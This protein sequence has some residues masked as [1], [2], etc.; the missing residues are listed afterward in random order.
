[1]V[2]L[3]VLAYLLFAFILPE[4]VEINE[5]PPFDLKVFG[6]DVAYAQEFLGSLS[7]IERKSYMRFLW[8]FDFVYPLIY[9]NLLII[10]LSFLS[11]PKKMGVFNLTPLLILLFDYSENTCS[12]YTTK[13][14]PEINSFVVQMGSVFTVLKWGLILL[15]IAVII[16]LLQRRIQAFLR[17]KRNAQE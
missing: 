3:S 2:L 17:G 1:M 11:K 8:T 16:Y 13:N 6:Y 10:L 4:L 5:L 15:S 9:G 7:E 14:F 12:Y